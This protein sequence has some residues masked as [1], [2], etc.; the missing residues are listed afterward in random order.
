MEVRP[1]RFAILG[2]LQRTSRLEFWRESNPEESRALVAE[3]AARAPD[4]VVTLGD[5]VFRGSSRRDWARVDALLAPLRGIAVHPILGN[6]EY[7]L[8]RG[9]ALRNFFERFPALGG[10][11]WRSEAYGPLGLVFLDSNEPQLGGGA[12][13]EQ[14]AWLG[15]ELA[16][17]DAEPAVR[18]VLVF[19]HHPPY[20]NSTVTG[21]GAHVQ[22]TFVPP[23]A[24]ARKTIA[25]VSG[26]VHSLERF[27]RDGKT[28][29]VAGGGGGPRVALARGDAR[30]H[31]DD[32][33]DGAAVRPF[34]FLEAVA[35]K[36]GLEIEVV[37]LEKG[38]RAF[39]ALARF[40]LPWPSGAPRP[41]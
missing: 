3:I 19:A 17:M 16:R 6:H 14:A 30:R 28:Y 39:A 13:A 36:G 25:M 15:R 26:H 35:G 18:G 9:P 38:A 21:D 40:T 37:G 41:S 31:A 2:D 11:R 12:W 29:L 24:G 10:R 32:L 34:H 4:F 5:L 22:R 27:L 20:T 23:F 7:W 8:R 1:G 33:V